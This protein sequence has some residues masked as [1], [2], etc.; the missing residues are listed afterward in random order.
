METEHEI[1]TPLPERPKELPEQLPEVIP[2]AIEM[3]DITPVVKT[4]EITDGKLHSY[5][6]SLNSLV[7][8]YAKSTGEN[9]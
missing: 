7:A 6:E 1:D 3:P 8:K 5:L 9:K 2:P 4:T